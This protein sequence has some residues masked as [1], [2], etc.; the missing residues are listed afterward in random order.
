M[1]TV[2][3]GVLVF[4]FEFFKTLECFDGDVVLCNKNYENA[5]FQNVNTKVPGRIISYAV[6]TLQS[7]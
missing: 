3:Y 4:L 7:L 1:L 6:F 5:P 2:A